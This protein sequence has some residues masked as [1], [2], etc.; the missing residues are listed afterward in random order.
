[1]KTTEWL[2][3]DGEVIQVILSDDVVLI[4]QNLQA[5]QN[6]LNGLN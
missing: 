2:H 3:V 1:M 5:L 4:A 6:P